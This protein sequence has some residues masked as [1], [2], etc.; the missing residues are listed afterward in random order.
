METSDNKNCELL[1]GLS[2]QTKDLK[3]DAVHLPIDAVICQEDIFLSQFG[4]EKFVEHKGDIVNFA[5]ETKV[6]RC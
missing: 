1:K 4:R 5:L 3:A 2:A 6:M